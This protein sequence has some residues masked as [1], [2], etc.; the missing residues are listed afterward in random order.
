MKL[1]DAINKGAAKLKGI[2]EN[3][4][5][6]SELL[7]AYCL[8]TDRTK[9]ILDREKELS[10]DNEKRFF[11]LINMRKD[12]IP[13]QYIVG[14]QYFMGMEFIVN[15]DVLIPR[16]DTEVLVEEVIKR[17]KRG[18]YVLDIGTGSGAIAV[19]IARHFKE[20]FVYAVDVSGDAL[21]TAK[22]NAEINGVVD[23]IKYIESDLFS[24]VPKDLKFDFIVS[25]PPYIKSSEIQALQEEVKREPIIALDGGCDGLEF[26]RKIIKEAPNY[27]NMGGMIGLEAGY[28]Q[29]DEIFNILTDGG[30]TDIEIICDLHGIKRVIIAAYS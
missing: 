29:A 9:L 6:E 12:R 22:I 7:L 19:S 2:C 21:K 30:F 15:P 27:I 10:A 18:S 5:F 20:C 8:R 14:K 23:R 4:R 17:L 25:N 13:Y 28:G 16:P 11:D 3:P 26:Y 1:Y 24:A